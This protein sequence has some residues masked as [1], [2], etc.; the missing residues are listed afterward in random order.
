MKN[1]AASGRGP[2]MPVPEIFSEKVAC[3]LFPPIADPA[4]SRSI[5]APTGQACRDCAVTRCRG[6]PDQR[7]PAE[8]DRLS[9]AARLLAARVRAD[10]DLLI[11]GWPPFPPPFF[12]SL[13]SF[14]AR[15]N[16][17]V[18]GFFDLRVPGQPPMDILRQ[19]R[20]PP[21]LKHRLQ[22]CHDGSLGGRMGE[23]Q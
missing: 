8:E 3:P 5:P 21:D 16:N 7:K 22:V 17:P 6:R 13:L 10:R 20:W 23:P 2:E 11:D 4:S 9:P 12:S 1:Y 19:G 14:L 18:P 15:E